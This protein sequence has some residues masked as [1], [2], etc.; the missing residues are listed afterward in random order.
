M[1]DEALFNRLLNGQEESMKHLSKIGEIVRRH[2]EVT[3]PEMKTE[4]NKQSQALIR[5]ESK[6]NEDMSRFMAEKEK[7]YQE[8][9]KRLEPLEN[10]LKTRRDFTTDV[11]KKSWD[12]IWDWLKI[13][14]VFVAGYLLTLIKEIK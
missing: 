4:L 5:M 7:V 2:D 14:I 13:G 12:T 8:F 6:Q 9:N 11:K 1:K 10:D 3:F